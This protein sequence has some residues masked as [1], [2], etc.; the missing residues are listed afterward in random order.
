MRIQSELQVVHRSATSWPVR[1]SSP[2]L[3]MHCD[4]RD[5][6]RQDQIEIQW[7]SQVLLHVQ[8]GVNVRLPSHR[9]VFSISA[10][11]LLKGLHSAWSSFVAGAGMY[12]RSIHTL[13]GRVSE[14]QNLLSAVTTNPRR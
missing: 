12:E 7:G 3:L 2:Q 4:S 9:L 11:V 8:D 6:C 13:C 1:C 14:G 10:A 5:R